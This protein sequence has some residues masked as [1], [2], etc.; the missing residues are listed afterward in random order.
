MKKSFGGGAQPGG[1]KREFIRVDTA[2]Y[3]CS[4]S[5]RPTKDATSTFWKVPLPS[6]SRRFIN[7]GGREEALGDRRL[8][9]SN[10]P[11]D[12]A[13]TTRRRP[14]PMASISRPERQRP[15]TKQDR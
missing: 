7:M 13:K 12:Y 4:T 6:L 9:R 15:P 1:R 11:G 10:S 14:P 2:N 3:S 8:A 5:S